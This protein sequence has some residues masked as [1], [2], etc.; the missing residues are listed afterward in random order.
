MKVVLKSVLKVYGELLATMVGKGEKL[1]LSVVNLDTL[2]TVSDILTSFVFIA[3]LNKLC[4]LHY[5]IFLYSIDAIGYSNAY[6]GEG[7]G[8]IELD[9]VICLGTES[10]LLDCSHSTI[11]T[12]SCEHYDDAGVKCQ[13]MCTCKKHVIVLIGNT[14]KY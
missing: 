1:R 6:F 9:D 3:L 4:I 2:P 5:N 14:I 13:S 12:S 10:T 8:T 7:T 11:G